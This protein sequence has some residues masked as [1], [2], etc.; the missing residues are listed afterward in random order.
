ML[1]DA[2]EPAATLPV[3]VT[4]PLFDACNVYAPAAT[5]LRVTDPSEPV[6]SLNLVWPEDWLVEDTTT[7]ETAPP[8]E[9]FTL[10][11]R[12]PV[13]CVGFW[14]ELLLYSARKAVTNH[15]TVTLHVAVH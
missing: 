14:F 1:T 10:N 5:L 4:Y 13:V 12:L 11:T 2:D 6:V 8:L 9:S 7:P 15:R 3:P